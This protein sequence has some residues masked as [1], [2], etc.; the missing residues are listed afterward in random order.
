MSKEQDTD[1]NICRD[2]YKGIKFPPASRE[3]DLEALREYVAEWN[4]AHP[5][6]KVETLP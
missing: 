5:K 4:K 6:I 2:T 3:K 1:Y